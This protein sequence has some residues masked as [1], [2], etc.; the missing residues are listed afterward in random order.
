MPNSAA[1]NR[2]RKRR[3]LNLKL[4]KEGR[5]AIQVKRYREKHKNDKPVYGYR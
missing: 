1:K 5:T 2:K 3:L 4:K